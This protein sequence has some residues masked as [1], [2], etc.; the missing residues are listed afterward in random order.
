M[1]RFVLSR[2]AVLR[3]AAGAAVALPPLEIVCPRG[4]RAAA[5]AIPKRFM[6]S[7]GGVSHGGCNQPIENNMVIPKK[8]GAGY[9]L[10]RGL[11]PLGDATYAGGVSGNVRNDVGIVS[12]LK[13]PVASGNGPAGPG[14]MIE[15]AGF[16]FC[17]MR[18]Q[19]TGERNTSTMLATD[20]GPIL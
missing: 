20:G 14:G 13:I 4:A 15:A 17:A 12:G 10:T 16:H 19:L 9:E 2:R 3:G 18:P 6:A 5:A 11:M 1:A 8:L 7:W